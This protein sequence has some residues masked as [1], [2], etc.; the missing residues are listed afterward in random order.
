MANS[1]QNDL[2]DCDIDDL[3]LSQ[4]IDEPERKYLLHY[5]GDDDITL[6]QAVDAVNQAVNYNNVVK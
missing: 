3:V 2:D 1:N 6:P 5:A 4:V